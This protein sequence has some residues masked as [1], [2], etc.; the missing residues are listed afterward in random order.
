[1]LHANFGDHNYP[2]AQPVPEYLTDLYL[3]I[4][5]LLRNN[6][7]GAEL[8]AETLSQ[9]REQIGSRGVLSRLDEMTSRGLVRPSVSP[10]ADARCHEPLAERLE[11]WEITEEGRAVVESHSGVAHVPYGRDVADDQHDQDRDGGVRSLHLAHG[12][13]FSRWLEPANWTSEN[14]SSTSFGNAGSQYTSE[15]RYR[16]VPLMG[17]SQNRLVYTGSGC[18]EPSS[19]PYK[20]GG[21]GPN[22][23]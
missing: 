20:G 10:R 8:L 15:G 18:L 12:N 19:C 9:Q 6:T 7:Q 11:A 5:D 21:A 2:Y 22:L 16:R 13:R 23:A 1:M 17:P 14:A 4:L 3:E